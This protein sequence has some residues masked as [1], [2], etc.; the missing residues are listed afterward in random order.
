MKFTIAKE[1]RDF[2]Q[3]FGWIELEGLLSH[4]QVNA[5]RQ[6]IELV[7]S[8][9]LQTSPEKLC[10]KSSEQMFL[11]GHDLWR[12]DI[13]L[14]KLITHNRF[15]ELIVELFEKKTLRL[16]YDQFLPAS[17]N[18]PGTTSSVYSLFL[19]KK[20][21]LEE[22]S[23]L[24]GLVCGMMI[25]V[26]PSQSSAFDKTPIP[27]NPVKELD[28]FPSQ[29]GNII[30]FQPNIQINWDTFRNPHEQIGQ[31]YYLVAYTL[32][33]AHYQLNSEDPH[34]HSLKRL[35]YVFNDKLRDKLNPMIYR[36]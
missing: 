33:T 20:K 35:G 25:A 28:N 34:T 9:R 15:S 13:Y 27:K 18:S 30:I 10:S 8:S 22:I 16:G 21:T 14:Q 17:S 32:G 11:Q 4:E 36:R 5:M 2:F 23:C 7:L 1:H 24:Q 3:K 12:A 6:S 29:E 19:Q 26:G 31:R